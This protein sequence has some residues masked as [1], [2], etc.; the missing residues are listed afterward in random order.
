M[1]HKPMAK[2]QFSIDMILGNSKSEE[3][4]QNDVKLQREFNQEKGINVS[5]TIRFNSP[6]S[7]EIKND[8]IEGENR[9]KLR[10]NRTTFTTYQLHQLERSFDKTQYPDVFTRENLALK[11]DLSEARVQV[12]FQNRRAKWRKREKVMQFG[13]SPSNSVCSSAIEYHQD[14][15][16][17][18]PEVPILEVTPIV[19]RSFIAN[20]QSCSCSHITDNKHLGYDNSSLIKPTLPHTCTARSCLYYGGKRHKNRFSDLRCSHEENFNKRTFHKIIY[21]EPCN[22]RYTD[23]SDHTDHSLRYS[24]FH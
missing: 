1:I 23:L 6:I 14:S 11:L 13:N 10:R 4:Q 8:E 7:S 12:W 18:I 17:S 16:I 5:S 9:Q 2:M 21:Q 22:R 15:Q 20:K 24:Y 19:K 3:K